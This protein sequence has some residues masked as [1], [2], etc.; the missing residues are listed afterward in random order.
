LRT[1]AGVG[2][3]GLVAG[4]ALGAAVPVAVARSARPSGEAESGARDRAGADEQFVVYVRD[5]RSGELDIFSGAS[6]TRL[7]D[8][9]LAARLYR[10]V[11]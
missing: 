5:P 7:V 9:D 11:G 1:V 2:A 6:H 10:A 8:R 4:G 3:V